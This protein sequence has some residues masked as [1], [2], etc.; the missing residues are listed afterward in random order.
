MRVSGCVWF[1]A[2]VGVCQVGVCAQR[3]PD[4]DEGAEKGRKEESL[5][6]V[7]VV[8][9]FCQAGKPCGRN[10]GRH[11]RLSNWHGKSRFWCFLCYSWHHCALIC[12]VSLHISLVFC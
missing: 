8:L 10:M 7:V 5:L 11:G 9:A 4:D 6:F 3:E 12:H 1:D 2:E